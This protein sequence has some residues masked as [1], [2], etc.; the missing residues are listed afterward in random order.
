MRA[1]SW[2]RREGDWEPQRLVVLEFPSVEDARRWY[3]SEEYRAAREIRERSATTKLL[4]VEGAS[5][6]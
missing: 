2:E 6:A 1:G 4:I 5:P 3:E